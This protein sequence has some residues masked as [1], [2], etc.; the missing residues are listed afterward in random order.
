M[1]KM[2]VYPLSLP[3]KEPAVRSLVSRRPIAAVALVSTTVPLFRY[4]LPRLF[5]GND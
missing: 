5:P 2:G 3:S 1:A 4:V